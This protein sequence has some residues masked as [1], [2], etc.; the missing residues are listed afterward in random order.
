MRIQTDKGNFDLPARESVFQST[1]TYRAEQS[2]LETELAVTG[3]R[4]LGP[5][6]P[7]HFALGERGIPILATE[8]GL[9]TI[10]I[11]QGTLGLKHYD[12]EYYTT[13]LYGERIR[14]GA[15]F[16]WDAG[17]EALTGN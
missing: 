3:V 15:V 1:A 6:T 12:L 16:G 4:L 11:S 14:H 10:T 8:R 17:K 13:E 2:G 7:V 5:P 9:W